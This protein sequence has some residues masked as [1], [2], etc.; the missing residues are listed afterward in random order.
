MKKYSLLL[1]FIIF[2]SHAQPLNQKAVV[3]VPVADCVGQALSNF[4]PQEQIEEK[5]RAI[6]ISWAGAANNMYSCPRIHQLLFNEVV[7]IIEQQGDEVLVEI[8]QVFYE[9]LDS[10]TRY[11]QFWT[12][13][14]NLAKVSD[15][16]TNVIPDQLDYHFPEKTNSDAIALMVPY[17]NT[18]TDRL[19]S[20]GTRFTLTEASDE[21]YTISF[22]D[23]TTKAIITDKLPT[24]I[25]YR[26]SKK[27]IDEQIKDFIALLRLWAT[28]S[29]GLIPL[30]WGGVSFTKWYPDVSCNQVEKRLP[31]GQIVSFWQPATTLST[32]F[33]GFDNSGLVLRAAQICGIPYFY[34]NTITAAKNMCPL[35]TQDILKEGDLLWVPGGLL[36]VSDLAHNKILTAIGYQF[37]Y[38]KVVELELEQLFVDI[39]TYQDLKD[40]YDQHK[41]IQ[42]KKVDGTISRTI[43]EYKLLKLA[44]VWE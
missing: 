39:H 30:V 9:K 18:Q 10:P 19:Y 33:S 28:S 6:P 24:T 37:G 26:A 44:S 12:L 35:S 2:Y 3:I 7:T 16:I 8:P 38:G 5:Y 14:K 40:A 42:T 11:N 27:I 41:P 36:V 4:H 1:F 20:A 22:Y 21:L 34:K 43:A 29:E 23:H 15:I 13:K 31:D 32:P 25:C 17:Y